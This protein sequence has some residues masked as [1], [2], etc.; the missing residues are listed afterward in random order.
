M[1]FQKLLI[2][3]LITG[4]ALLGL[5][6]FSSFSKAVLIGD[7]MPQEPIGNPGDE[8]ALENYIAWAEAERKCTSGGGC[9]LTT[10]EPKL[11]GRYIG[12]YLVSYRT[13]DRYSESGGKW[14]CNDTR[15]GDSEG[16]FASGFGILLA[17]KT[18][19][20]TNR[21]NLSILLPMDVEA[22]QGIEPGG[23]EIYDALRGFSIHKKAMI[24]TRWNLNQDVATKKYSYEFVGLVGGNPGT[25][26]CGTGEGQVTVCGRVFLEQV[27]SVSG[28]A[29]D[30]SPSIFE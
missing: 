16:Q 17:Q 20:G 11:L 29:Y 18:G 8:L 27:L 30:Y 9:V 24:W 21:R 7:S 23:Q 10:G 1:A 22:L 19:S 14:I 4:I 15:S 12:A 26:Y 2:V 5:G 6:M 3:I 28:R 25:A 13:C